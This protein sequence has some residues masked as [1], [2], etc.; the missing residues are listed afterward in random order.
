MAGVAKTTAAAA[1]RRYLRIGVVTLSCSFPVAA[2]NMLQCRK[3]RGSESPG[4]LK[5]KLLRACH[6]WTDDHAR[7]TVRIKGKRA[8]NSNHAA[9][10]PG[11]IVDG[12]AVVTWRLS[13]GNFLE[14]DLDPR[15]HRRTDRDLLDELALGARRPGLD[16]GVHERAEIGAEVGFGEARLA[17]PGVD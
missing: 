12:Y 14:V 9:P 16:D 5:P 8:G 6:S 7:Q 11:S 2:P 13:S 1:A 17:D 4:R 10:A 3:F 15:A